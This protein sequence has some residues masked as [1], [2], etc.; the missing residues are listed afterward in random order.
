MTIWRGKA[1]TEEDAR[2]LLVAHLDDPAAPKGGQKL[3]VSW[4]VACGANVAYDQFSSQHQIFYPA[5][6]GKDMWYDP[7]FRVNTLDNRNIWCKR[8]YKVRPATVPGTFRFSVSDNGVTSDEFWTI[9]AAADDLSWIVFHYAGAAKTVGLRY[10]GGL[11]CTPD[12]GLPEEHQLPQIWD[13]FRS[14]GIQPWELYLVDNRKDTPASI[15]AGPPPLDYY[16]A[17][18]LKRR[19]AEGAS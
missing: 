16:R 9:V 14:A 19:L 11:L 6:R 7:F 18:T 3:D 15:E 13:S 8:H 4:M 1:L 5:A 12:G 10:L 2:A 17:E